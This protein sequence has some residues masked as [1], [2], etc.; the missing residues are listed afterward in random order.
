MT[1]RWWGRLARSP[2]NPTGLPGDMSINRYVV[3][4]GILTRQ[5]A[6][7]DPAPIPDLPAGHRLG[8]VLDFTPTQTWG[9]QGGEMLLC[10]R[11]QTYNDTHSEDEDS[12]PYLI[13]T[14][15]VPGDPPPAMF[16]GCQT[17]IGPQSY[18][19]S[20]QYWAR[21]WGLNSG[22]QH[23]VVRARTNTDGDMHK[24][25]NAYSMTYIS[26]YQIRR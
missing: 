2:G 6:N 1:P 8:A 9:L 17:R 5:T 15:G 12:F 21:Q 13:L 7:H 3:G 11:F 10:A 26:L 20:D 19:D 25:D 4:G 16:T 23:V 24:Y 22:P 14:G 18:K